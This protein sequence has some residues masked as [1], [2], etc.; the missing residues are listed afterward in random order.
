ML[1]I[2]KIN[3]LGLKNNASNEEFAAKKLQNLKPGLSHMF[4]LGAHAIK[5]AQ[6]SF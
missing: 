3:D 2:N 1:N 6:Y 4:P 5:T